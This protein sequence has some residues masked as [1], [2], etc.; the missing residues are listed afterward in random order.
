MCVYHREPNQTE[1]LSQEL[2]SIC[3][4]SLR[5]PHEHIRQGNGRTVHNSNLS[6]WCEP[7]RCWTSDT[8]THWHCTLCNVH[9]TR[10]QA[11]TIICG[12]YDNAWIS[13]RQHLQNKIVQPRFTFNKN[14]EFVVSMPYIS[15]TFCFACQYEFPL[16]HYLVMTMSGSRHRTTVVGDD[17]HTN[18]RHLA[19]FFGS[20]KPIWKHCIQLLL[21]D[22]NS[23]SS[24]FQP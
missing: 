16:L 13:S 8:H 20:N 6:G 5:S 11:H 19:H 21:T 23:T 9:M 14:T 3:L 1:G 4:H 18:C 7:W 17:M 24:H 2:N 22:T 10:C 12:S 15:G